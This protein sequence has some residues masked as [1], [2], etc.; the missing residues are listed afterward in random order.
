MQ[1]KYVGD[2]GD[3][4]K[5]SLLRRLA[6]ATA[7]DN[8]PPLR[9]GLV[10]YAR[11]D[12]CGNLDGKFVQYLDPT[13]KNL[14]TF[15]DCDFELWTKLRGL[16]D[17]N[18]RCIHCAERARILPEGTA[19]Y[20]PALAFVAG[21]PRDV[22]ATIREHWFGL[23][24]RVTAGADLV[25]LDP[26]NGVRWDGSKMFQQDGPKFTYI[27]DLRAFWDRGQSLVVYQHADRVLGS[28]QDISA[29]LRDSL[30][31]DPIPLW[32]HRGAARVFFVLPQPAHREAITQRVADL[33][34]AR[35]RRVATSSGL[36]GQ[37]D[38][39]ENSG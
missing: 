37:H 20:R 18:A 30:G 23:A 27:S 8:L 19:Y 29:S 34:A 16:V 22:K 36:G 9:L 28:A 10:W 25:C 1:N 6:G 24:L 31:T 35:G 12:E 26:D 7:P 14:D 3:F 39:S 2:V 11:S 15:G 5:H 38:D 13:R 4:G 17:G 32:F 21:M 33:L